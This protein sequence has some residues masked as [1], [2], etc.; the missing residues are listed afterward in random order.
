MGNS[1]YFR[2]L[3]SRQLDNKGNSI[4]V[5]DDDER[6][7]DGASRYIRLFS[8]SDTGKDPTARELLVL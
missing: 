7:V 4:T 2:F 8:T 6:A 5:G 3:L 1:G